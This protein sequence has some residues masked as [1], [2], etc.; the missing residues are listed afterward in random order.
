MWDFVVFRQVIATFIEPYLGQILPYWGQ[1][2]TIE[3]ATTSSTKM[4]R[5]VET[6]WGSFG[7]AGGQKP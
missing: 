2:G 3:R 6:D 4:S 5:G 1:V 7:G